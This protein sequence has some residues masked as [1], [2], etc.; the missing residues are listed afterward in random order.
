MAFRAQLKPWLWLLPFIHI[1]CAG[2]LS[3][4]G[5]DA[6]TL[7]QRALAPGIFVMAFCMPWFEPCKA[8]TLELTVAAES[9]VKTSEVDVYEFDCLEDNGFCAS[10][11]VL[12]FPTI[13]IFDHREWTR[14]RGTPK[15]S[16]VV[17]HVLKRVL[18]PIVELDEQRFGAMKTLD[19]PLLVLT[20][21]RDD[22]LS[23]NVMSSL[24]RQ[25]LSGHFFVGVMTDSPFAGTVG[26]TPPF[27]TVFNVLDE[28]IPTYQGPFERTAVLEFANK[29]FL[30]LIRQFDLSSLVSSVKSGLP[31]AMVFSA[32]EG[33]RKSLAKSLTGIAMKYRGQVNFAT[34]DAEKQSLFL[35]HFGLYA[36]H[37]PAFIIQTTDDVFIFK[38]DS[39]I[40]ANAIDEFIRQT[41]RSIMA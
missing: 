14:Y 8:L 18:D 24:A 23:L 39:Q 7:E 3:L 17:S 40:T 12:S 15:A 10:M 5:I 26:T 34:V 37:L 30:P 36:D 13:R 1:C 35:E 21:T 2:E 29:V 20:R 28:T 31:L 11:E 33:E 25:E 22:D 38:Q 27:V 6:E 4:S 9:L 32:D 19:P 41:I 16:S